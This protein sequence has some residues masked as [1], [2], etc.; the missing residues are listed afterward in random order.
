VGARV[1]EAL[2]L[3]VETVLTEL[4]KSLF[5]KPLLRNSLH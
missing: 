1:L 5:V 3:G 2:D 4:K